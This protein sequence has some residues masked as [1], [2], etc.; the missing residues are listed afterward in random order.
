MRT[1]AALRREHGQ[2]R[3][4]G[5]RYGEAQRQGRRRQGMMEPIGF[6][7]TEWMPMSI[8]ISQAASFTSRRTKGRE[9]APT[10]CRSGHDR[11]HEVA[12]PAAR[13]TPISRRCCMAHWQ[14]WIQP[15]SNKNLECLDRMTVLESNRMK[16]AAEKIA[17]A[18]QASESHQARHLHHQRESHLRSDLRRSQAG[19]QAA[20][21]T[22]IPA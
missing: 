5:D 11:R 2:R 16:A 21:A 13:I 22:A 10:T 19:R 17:F 6:V 3:G 7:P 12:A 18:G 9:P 4:C 1:A 14:C 8:G 20:S 15:T